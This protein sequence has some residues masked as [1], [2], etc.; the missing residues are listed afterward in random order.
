MGLVIVVTL[1][2]D[3]GMVEPGRLAMLDATEQGEETVPV[4]FVERQVHSVL[5]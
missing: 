3:G 2:R 1:T 5:T 4:D